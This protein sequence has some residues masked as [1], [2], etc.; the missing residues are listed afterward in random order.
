[1]HF[2]GNEEGGSSQNLRQNIQHNMKG[3]RPNAGLAP[4]FTQLIAS[5]DHIDGSALMVALL[6]DAAEAKASDV[7][8]DP[9][10]QAHRIRF[11]IDGT[12][13]DTGRVPRATG[14]HIVRA[15]QVAAEID[16]NST[17]E[18]FDGRSIHGDSNPSDVRIATAPGMLGDK[19]T[20]RLL[21]EKDIIYHLERLG[22]EADLEELVRRIVET[23]QGM[24]LVSGSSGSGKT[25]TAYAL[26]TELLS[27]KI[28]LL[29]LEDPVEY[30]LE[31]ATQIEINE[32]SGLTYAEGIRALLRH[33]P[34]CLFLG[35]IRDAGIATTAVDA[36]FS[37]HTMISTV[38]A[39]RAVST[40]TML[41]AMGVAR[42]MLAPALR[43]IINQRLIRRPCEA[44]RDVR[45]L[46][47]QEET[48]MRSA[49]LEPV[50]K[51]AIAPG[52]PEC[53]GS[54][55]GGRR[56]VFEAWEIDDEAYQR[57]LD[58]ADDHL[59]AKAFEAQGKTLLQHGRRLVE[60]GE[61][62]L[63]EL[64]SLT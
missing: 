52:C 9:L 14:E 62:G 49:G 13:H 15:F 48:W 28:N 12:L 18:A 50:K 43:L 47:L 57:I 38:H 55:Y 29:T 40:A 41:R 4:R 61:I 30:V 5:E 17:R 63:A 54:G 56:A 16:S 10:N 34:D 32:E 24:I 7:H 64:R 3:P 21:Q 2:M 35:E 22:M 60:R 42:H 36:C 26:L 25:T 23:H 37:G 58:D 44:C 51:T 8:I 45:H 1:M 59:M 11:R 31:G 27:R 53:A 20:A 19:I 39:R 6:Q 33:D 46:T